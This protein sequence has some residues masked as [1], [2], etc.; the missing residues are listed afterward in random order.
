M[1]EYANSGIINPNKYKRPGTRMPDFNGKAKTTCVHCKCE[2]EFEVAAWDKGRYTTLA[3]TEKSAAAAKKAAAAAQRA[4]LP[5]AAEQA[6]NQAAD[7]A[8]ST[9]TEND[10]EPKTGDALF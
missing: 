3:F 6:S 10:G 8:A 4:G 5:T 2:T 9:T 7:D 1:S